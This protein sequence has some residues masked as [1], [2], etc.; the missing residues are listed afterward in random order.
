MPPARS[1]CSSVAVI[2]CGQWGSNLIR[3]FADS[4]TLSAV[5]DIVQSR[6][7]DAAKL[8]RTTHNHLIPTRDWASIL[9]DPSITAIVI[10][11]PAACHADMAIEALTAGKHVF[12]EKPLALTVLESKRVQAVAHQAHRIVMVGHT[13]RYHPA[14]EKLR[15]FVRLGVLGKVLQIQSRRLAFGR[16]RHDEN[17]FW[18]LAPHDISMILG[19]F[20]NV[21]AVV[22]QTYGESLLRPGTTILDTVNAHFKLSN[23]VSAGVHV[24]WLNPHKERKMIVIGEEATAVFDDTEPWE[25]KLCVFKNKIDW[26]SGH[27][28]APDSRMEVI[29]LEKV[30]PLANECQHFL[31]CVRTGKVPRTDLAEGMAVVG[32]LEAVETELRMR[33]SIRQPSILTSGLHSDPKTE[34]ANEI[35]APNLQDKCVKISIID[36]Q[37]QRRR[38]QQPL[39]QRLSR[40]FNHMKFIMG[41]EVYELEEKL[42]A[43]TGATHAVTCASGTD[44]LTLAMLALGVGPG[45]AVLVPALTF[46][47]S[48]EPVVL[49]GAIPIIVDVES[50]TLTINPAQIGAGVVAARKAGLR[51][52]GVIAVDLFG[53]PANYNGI[54]SA[55]AEL[56]EES[57][58]IIADAAQSFG[59]SV[60]EAKVG[61]LADI[62]TTSFFPSKPLGCYGDGGAA[63][64]NNPE[65]ASML[66]S[67]RLHGRDEKEKYE[68]VHIGVNSRLDTIQAAILLCKLDILADEIA[69]R[70][71]VASRYTS[72]LQNGVK[73]KDGSNATLCWPAALP[74]DGTVS[75][76]AAYTIRTT[77]VKR[78][79]I[80]T[81]LHQNGVESVIYYPIPVHQQA[82]YR[83][84]PVANGHCPTAE[85]ACREVISI[86][87]HPY[88]KASVQA[89]I[90]SLLVGTT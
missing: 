72:L 66:R 59:A 30:E 15:D 89:H 74:L 48:V 5:S 6:A 12:I 37:S 61:T 21:N 35:S 60:N 36:L 52:V 20:D 64:T 40:V 13:F 16:V 57:L 73:D 67:L 24:S 11:T 71:V 53:T 26:T 32:V 56:E 86:P 85:S 83:N 69:S 29:A 14:F 46:I 19:L 4:G 47:A 44:A 45:D 65:T 39:E 77:D 17:V 81:R 55:I 42:C 3:V 79:Q 90:T 87:M 50:Q 84:F 27:P 1:D 70:Q 28:E 76:W 78:S 54:R 7:N 8:L 75:A 10:A 9:A 82:A 38:I 25:S 43:V 68:N 41:P 63:F 31:D 18:S 88:L 22:V 80:Q 2:G 51:P 49:L 58:W 34:V 62:T 23:G 33:N